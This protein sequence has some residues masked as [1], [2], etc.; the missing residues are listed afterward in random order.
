MLS[1]HC[2]ALVA[3]TTYRYR[4]LT[5]NVCPSEPLKCICQLTLLQISGSPFR[6]KAFGRTLR[7][8]EPQ[9]TTFT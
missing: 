7:T 5:N 3:L 9:A 8:T 4:L 1:P 6:S 2:V